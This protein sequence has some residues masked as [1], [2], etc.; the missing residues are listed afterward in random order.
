AM[1]SMIGLFY[2]Y[3]VE[4]TVVLALFTINLVALYLFSSSMLVK[5]CRM[6]KL[7]ENLQTLTK[8]HRANIDCHPYK[9]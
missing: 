8:L 1:L 9:K 4:Q 2:L 7:R 6:K 3:D 5:Q